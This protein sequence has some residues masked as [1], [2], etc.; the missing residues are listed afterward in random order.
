MLYRDADTGLDYAM[1]R[2]YFSA[3]GRFAQPVSRVSQHLAELLAPWVLARYHLLS[4][5]A[6]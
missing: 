6:R 5:N 4:S 1:A 2:Y 3:I